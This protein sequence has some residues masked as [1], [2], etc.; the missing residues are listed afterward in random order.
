MKCAG[1]DNADFLHMIFLM[2]KFYARVANS[3]A[4]VQHKF[5]RGK[6]MSIISCGQCNSP[7]QLS[8]YFHQI[9]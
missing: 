7:F 3:S 2:M 8:W 6:I 1:R 4:V 9:K 5:R